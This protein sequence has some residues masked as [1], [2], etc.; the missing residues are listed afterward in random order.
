MSDNGIELSVTYK[1]GSKVV[2]AVRLGFGDGHAISIAVEKDKTS[3][4]MVGRQI[5]LTLDA[6]G[7][8]CEFERAVNLLRLHIR[9]IS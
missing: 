8:G 7:P 1:P 2:Q 6:T 3:L 4:Q 9:Q 5:D